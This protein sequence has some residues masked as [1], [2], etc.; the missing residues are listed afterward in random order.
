M[1]VLAGLAGT[2]EA[3]TYKIKKKD[4]NY[5]H[6]TEAAEPTGATQRIERKTLSGTVPSGALPAGSEFIL[7]TDSTTSSEYHYFPYRPK[8]PA[9]MPP[10]DPAPGLENADRPRNRLPNTDVIYQPR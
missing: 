5:K 1:L 4:H 3:Q 2:A 9:E 10:D 7:I 8:T 6:K